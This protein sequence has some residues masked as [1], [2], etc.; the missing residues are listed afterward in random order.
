MHTHPESG[1]GI[2][3]WG[4]PTISSSH[5]QVSLQPHLHHT[6]HQHVNGATFEQHPQVHEEKPHATHSQNSSISK[7]TQQLSFTVLVISWRTNYRVLV[8]SWRISWVIK[9]QKKDIINVGIHLSNIPYF[10]TYHLWPDIGFK[11]TC[12]TTYKSRMKDN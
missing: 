6:I 8:A 1:K 4:C 5:L 9:L 11:T 7:K 3:E 2:Q 12:S 10:K